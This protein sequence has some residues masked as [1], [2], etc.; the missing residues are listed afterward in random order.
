MDVIQ[1]NLLKEGDY[2]LYKAKDWCRISKIDVMFYE[3]FLSIEARHVFTKKKYLWMY[4]PYFARTFIVWKQYYRIFNIEQNIY[5]TLID[6][7]GNSIDV[8]GDD[9]EI[10]SAFNKNLDVIVTVLS[11]GKNKQI[12]HYF[13]NIHK[14]ALED[15]VGKRHL[16][17][18]YYVLFD[19][20][21]DSC[22]YDKYEI[23]DILSK[24]DPRNYNYLAYHIAKNLN[25]ELAINIITNKIIKLNWY[26]R[27]VFEF[28][29]I[30]LNSES[31]IVSENIHQHTRKLFS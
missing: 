12:I 6:Y 28:G 29:I 16:C 24:L 23:Y 2:I 30:L 21:Y 22:K 26:E 15:Y 11:D 19:V 27:R 4:S 18:T 25:N 17:Y 31:T 1:V 10:T 20:I 8:L 14:L 7:D 13:F 3:L 5:W 9:F